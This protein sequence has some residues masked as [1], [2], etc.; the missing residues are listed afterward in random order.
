MNTVYYTVGSQPKQTPAYTSWEI[1]S[2]KVSHNVVVIFEQKKEGFGCM[3]PESQQQ[4][5]LVNG[6]PISKWNGHRMIYIKQADLHMGWTNKNTDS[7]LSGWLSKPTASQRQ[8]DW[9]GGDW[10][11]A[12]NSEQRWGLIRGNSW[13]SGNGNTATVH[14][15][16]QRDR[17]NKHNETRKWR[18]GVK[19]GL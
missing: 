12:E 3:G 18:K 15:H 13:D 17:E 4:S 10:E 1:Q 6:Y 7:L 8:M 19:Y 9:E 16:G 11:T 14:P 5:Q 2:G